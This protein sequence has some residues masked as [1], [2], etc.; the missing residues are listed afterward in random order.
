L[1]KT[2]SSLEKHGLI[3]FHKI[4]WDWRRSFEEAVELVSDKI[5]LLTSSS[6]KAIVVTHSTGALVTWPTIDQHPEWISCWINVAGCLT[7]GSNMFLSEFLMGWRKHGIQMFHEE[8]FFSFAGLYSYFPLLGQEEFGGVGESDY[9]R[10]DG[11]FCHEL[12]IYKVETWQEYK[13]GIYGWKNDVTEE[14]RSHLQ[15]SLDAAK[16]LRE[17]ILVKKGGN[18]HEASFLEHE[19]A[20]YQHLKIICYGT[21]KLQTHSAYLLSDDSKLDVSSSKLTAPGDGTLFATNWQTI[22]GG[23]PHEIIMAQDGSDHVSLVNDTKLQKVMVESFFD[24]D[25]V[26]KASAFALLKLA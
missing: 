15:H 6:Q 19:I 25:P 4:V 21:D 17:S 12:D 5:Q 3:E 26:T 22:P 13:L 7:K 11:S 20:C 18:Q 14:E 1:L 23:L 24:N 2:L 9:V 16:R 10:Q 8:T